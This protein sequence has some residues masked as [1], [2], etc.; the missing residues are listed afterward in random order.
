MSTA[1]IMW[2]TGLMLANKKLA[3]TH[4]CDITLECNAIHSDTIYNAWI[5]A[6]INIGGYIWAFIQVYMENTNGLF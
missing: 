4:K 3:Y 5:G 2:D 6:P 1:F